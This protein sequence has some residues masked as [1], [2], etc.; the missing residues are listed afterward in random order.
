V[1]QAKPK[2]ALPARS[3]RLENAI[4]DLQALQ[5]VLLAGELDPRV[6]TDF[7]DALN[8]IRNIAWAAQQLVA[9]Q[10]LETGTADIT[11]LLASER[12]R[13][14]YRLCRAIGEDLEC[15]DLQFQK[16]QLSELHSTVAQLAAQLSEKLQPGNSKSQKR[17]KAVRAGV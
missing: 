2:P 7:R 3:G 12:I 16:G 14:A 15:D 8:R 10:V 1:K 11:S 6:L 5:Q 17:R 4:R 9:S 13:T